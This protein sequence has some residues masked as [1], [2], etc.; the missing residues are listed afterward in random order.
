MSGSSLDGID[1]AY[2]EFSV[3]AQGQWTFEIPLAECVPL[4]SVW[5]TRLLHLPEQSAVVFHK[6]HT[7]FGH[8][9]G[10]IAA[11]F[12]RQHHLEPQVIGSHGH[13]IFHAPAQQLTAQI[14]CGA[15]L[16]AAATIATVC[17]FRTLD[18]ALGGQGAPIVPIADRLLFAPY[19]YCLNLGGIANISAK[20]ATAIVAFDI[21]ACNGVLDRL[22]QTQNMPFDAGGALARSGALQ[23][24]WLDK[25]N[26]LR[27]LQQPYPKSLGNDWVRRIAQKLQE[28]EDTSTPDKLRTFCEHIA[29]QIKNS[30]L[31]IQERENTTNFATTDRL[32]LTG[33]GA[34][35]TFLSERIAAQCAG[36]CEV[37]IPDE[38]TIKFKEA[39]TMA[40]MA[41]LR[42]RGDNNVLASVTGARRDSCSGALYAA[43]GAPL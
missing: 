22:A 26:S 21:S 1:V 14:G 36:L 6:T 23:T 25:L 38:K 5:H 20:T 2:C 35:N 33:G 34:F 31:Q 7:Y 43:N 13:T 8:F 30:V 41:V 3:D 15:A 39:L 10:E 18:V 24:F 40:L 4:P 29:I 17:D 37:E 28:A 12:I 16:A 27:F 11:D 32:L 9:L 42:L 19:R